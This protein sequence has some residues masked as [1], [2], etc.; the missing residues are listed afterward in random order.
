M[1]Q[2]TSVLFDVPGPRAQRRN[3][4]VGIIG[5]TIVVGLLLL[6]IWRAW[7]KG[8]ITP[9]RF[10]AY[11][12]PELLNGLLEAILNTIKA[13]GAAI[14]LALVFG[15]VF[16]LL[17]LSDRAWIRWPAVAVIEFF[18]ATP[19][20]LLILFLYL[21]FAE[22]LGVYGALVV[23]LMLYN[24]SVLAEIFRAG[25]AAVPRGQSE[26]AYAIG[27]RKSQVLW[28]ILV[29]QAVRAM[30]PAIISQCVVALKDTSLGFVIGYAELA[31]FN[32]LVYTAENNILASTIVVTAIYIAMN[33]GLS[34]VAVWLERRQSRGG[35]P[36]LG[37]DMHVEAPRI[38]GSPNLVP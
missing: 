10:S 28:L 36:S 7:S 19:L 12:D 24:G 3:N 11:T 30:L 6:V 1:S 2:P 4:G 14:L 32:K 31:R 16:C 22:T 37:P 27:M 26:A 34:R 5:A 38:E 23:G 29:P 25:V 9:D 13:A 18:R 35:G 33:F 21:G 15:A 17:R 8:A 20:L